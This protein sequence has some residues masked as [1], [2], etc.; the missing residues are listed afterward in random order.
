LNPD[1]DFSNQGCIN[2]ADRNGAKITCGYSYWICDNG[3]GYILTAHFESESN[4][5]LYDQNASGMNTTSVIDD[6]TVVMN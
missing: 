1:G 5:D 2:P 6:Y 4:V 3:A